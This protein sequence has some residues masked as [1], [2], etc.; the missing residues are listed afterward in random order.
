[1]RVRVPGL[2]IMLH[3]SEDGEPRPKKTGNINQTEPD[4]TH[5]GVKKNDDEY[6]KRRPSHGIVRTFFLLSIFVSILSYKY[7]NRSIHPP[8]PLGLQS[9]S[10][11][12]RPPDRSMICMHSTTPRFCSSAA[13]SSTSA[14]SFALMIVYAWMTA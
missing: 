11:K 1:M 5:A 7:N 14:F 4:R 10:S 12:Y 3:V 8:T 6:T 13:I 2:V 9:S